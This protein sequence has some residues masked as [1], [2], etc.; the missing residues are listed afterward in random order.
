MTAINTSLLVE[1][2]EDAV[3]EFN[4][5]VNLASSVGISV[6]AEVHTQ[7]MVDAPTRPILMVQVV[8]P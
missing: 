2:I 7:Q 1:E 4:R 8:A 3:S 5:L 6:T